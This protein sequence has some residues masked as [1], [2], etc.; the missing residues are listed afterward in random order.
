MVYITHI[1]LSTNGKG[2][3]HITHLRWRDPATN[4]VSHS[5]REDMV[6]FIRN[7]GVVRVQDG[8]GEV[9]VQ[10][11]EASPPYVRTV[12]DGRYTDNLLALPHF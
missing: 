3:E 1:R 9:A 12:A 4:Q 6:V 11:V 8:R 5:T 10:V 2:H 7:N